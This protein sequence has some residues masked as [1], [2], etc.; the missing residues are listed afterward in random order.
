MNT[1]TLLLFLA[2]LVLLI[3]GAEILVRGAT[4]LAA[5][6]GIS[7]LVVG[8]TVVAFGTSAP[9]LA[10]TIQSSWAGQSDIALGNIVGSNICNILLILG[11]AALITPL[12]VSQKL[13]RLDVPLMIGLSLVVL[14]MGLDGLIS[15]LDGAILFAGIIIYTTWSIRQ[16][17]Q[18]SRK[19][20]QEYAQEY[21]SP[22]DQSPRQLL[23]YGGFVIA[24]LILLTIGSN[25]LVE[26]AIALARALGV[27]ELLIGLTIIAIGTSLPEVAA[28]VTASLKGERDIA[29]GNVIGSNIFNILS[30]LGLT[31]LVSP[32]GVNV[33]STALYFDIPVMIAV[34]VTCL[35]IFFNGHK[36]AR[37]EGGLLFGYYLTYN[38]YLILKATEHTILPLFAAAMIYFIIPLTV[39]TLVVILVRAMRTN[40]QPVMPG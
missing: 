11:L 37:W 21:G 24:G 19:I 7:P 36:V 6:L 4:R 3:G 32:N 34:A 30:V 26:G 14:L 23:L 8:L 10:V 35:P 29:V 20:K 38:L 13:I 9:E 27:S 12:V 2:G 15:R 28:S 16:S 1:I 18:E 40:R 25:W 5:A 33:P 22:P 39:I 31:S 17:R